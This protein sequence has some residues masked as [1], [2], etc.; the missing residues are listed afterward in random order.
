MRKSGS[1]SADDAA[2][3][4]AA[5][6][7][8]DAAL[9]AG[10]ARAALKL[11]ER[12]ARA[13]PASAELQHARGVAL[14]ALDRTEEALA[15]FEVATDLDPQHADAWLDAAEALAEDLGDTPQALQVLDDARAHLEGADDLAEVALL[16]GVV[17][18]HLEDYTG[19]LR[20]LED[21]ERAAPGHPEVLAEKG[22][23]LLEL[24]RLEDAERAARQAVARPEAGARA[25]QLLAFLLDYTGRRADALPWFV[26][27]GESDK[28]LPMAPPRLSEKEFDGAVEEALGSIPA[29]FRAHLDNVE[30]GVENYADLEFCRRHDCSPM[31]LGIFVGTPLPL[32]EGTA[33]GEALPDRIVLFQRALENHAADRAHLVDE[34]AVTLKH[35]VGHF[36][37][38]SEEELDE[39]GYG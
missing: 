32:R 10:D 17:L 3:V 24:L 26:K 38:F 14:R 7:A 5:L 15:A 16:R 12:H 28:E 22:W 35:E 18:S 6:A 29:P 19:A 37:G 36:L 20:A 2:D 4:E 1:G 27:A 11:A 13:H 31:T 25:Y 9:L 39:R 23:V 34:I 8:V 33:R 21:A 30:I